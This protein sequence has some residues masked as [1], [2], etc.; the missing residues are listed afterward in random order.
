MF[1]KS[2]TRILWVLVRKIPKSSQLF[3]ISKNI[4]LHSNDI[5]CV[6]R[7]YFHFQS[8]QTKPCSKMATAVASVKVPPTDAQITAKF[9]QLWEAISTQCSGVVCKDTV[10]QILA[11]PFLDWVLEHTELCP[12]KAPLLFSNHYYQIK[13]WFRPQ[14]EKRFLTLRKAFITQFPLEATAFAST[15]DQLHIVV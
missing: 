2:Q 5:L 15:M 10:D 7:R 4:K 8:T 3:V 1:A 14:T 6:I 13:P 9:R 12:D 11:H